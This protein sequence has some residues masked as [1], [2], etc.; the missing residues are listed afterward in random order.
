MVAYLKSSEICT[1]CKMYFYTYEDQV[2]MDRQA[3]RIEER[4]F[5]GFG[6]DI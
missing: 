5:Q 4:S 1:V 3:Q 2:A 6:L